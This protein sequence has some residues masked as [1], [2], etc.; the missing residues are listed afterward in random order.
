MA[1]QGKSKAIVSDSALNL[2][3]S[4]CREAEAVRQGVWAWAG[5][6]P[7]DL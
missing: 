4:P 5:A 2:M 7:G 3:K 6:I 1:P